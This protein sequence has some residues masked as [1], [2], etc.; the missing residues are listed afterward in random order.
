ML[1]Y[2]TYESGSN[3]ASFFG[4]DGSF[5]FSYHTLIAF[6]HPVTGLV[7][8]ENDWGPT[9]GKH[10]NGISPDKSKRVPSGEFEAIY[11]KTFNKELV[12]RLQLEA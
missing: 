7:I 8:R 5:Y 9:T 10:L 11:E 1:K 4:P 2:P 12:T 6:W 3:F